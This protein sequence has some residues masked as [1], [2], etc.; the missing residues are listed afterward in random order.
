MISG[1]FD[2][3]TSIA[4]AQREA[5]AMRGMSEAN[6]AATTRSPPPSRGDA[7]DANEKARAAA[8]VLQAKIAPDR[9]P[10]TNGKWSQTAPMCK[11]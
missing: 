3:I 2:G 1:G 8:L 9:D 7:V 10:C 5:R 11:R 6:Q 4:A